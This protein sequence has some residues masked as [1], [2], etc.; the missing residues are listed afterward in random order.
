MSQHAQLLPLNQ[1]TLIPHVPNAEEDS[2]TDSFLSKNYHF[3][4]QNTTVACLNNFILTSSTPMSII[5]YPSHPHNL[6]PM[7]QQF[8]CNCPEWLQASYRVIFHFQFL[9]NANKKNFSRYN[10]LIDP[11]RIGKQ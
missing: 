2:S 11:H 10:I 5:I 6:H 9:N 3:I 1:M 7:D 8:N 4:E